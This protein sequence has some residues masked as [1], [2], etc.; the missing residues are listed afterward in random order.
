MESRDLRFVERSWAGREAI[1][2]L[3]ALTKLGGARESVTYRR[4]PTI[5]KANKEV[6]G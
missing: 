1:I 5:M 4:V 6:V 3:E 2:H